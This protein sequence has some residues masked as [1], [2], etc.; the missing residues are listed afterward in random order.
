MNDLMISFL[1][2][3]M[4]LLFLITASCLYIPRKYQFCINRV[5]TED[6]ICLIFLVCVHFIFRKNKSIFQGCIYELMTVGAK[7]Y[8]LHT[9]PL[10]WVKTLVFIE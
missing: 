7:L 9:F 1:C 3:H 5:D 4:I 10:L 8:L 2:L 6:L